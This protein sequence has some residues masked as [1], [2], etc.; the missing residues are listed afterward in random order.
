MAC[1][2]LPTFDRILPCFRSPQHLVAGELSYFSARPTSRASREFFSS[3]FNLLVQLVTYFTYDIL[4]P[5]NGSGLSRRFLRL[6]TRYCVHCDRTRAPPLTHR[7]CT[8]QG[9]RGDGSP[10]GSCGDRRSRAK[11][12]IASVLFVRRHCWRLSLAAAIS[13]ACPVGA[14]LR[15]ARAQALSGPTRS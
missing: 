3:I 2:A 7:L 15:Q 14:C 9:R 13:P 1:P 11:S 6:D 10:S 5:L 4:G 8:A 12:L